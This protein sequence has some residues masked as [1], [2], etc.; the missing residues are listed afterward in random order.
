MK[1]VRLVAI[2]S[3]LSLHLSLLSLTTTSLHAGEIHDA[4]ATGDLNKVRSLIEADPTLLEA[5][6]DMGLTPLH[7]ACFTGQVAVANFLIA[8][9]ADVTA[10]DNF[11]MTPLHRTCFVPGQDLALIQRL[12]GQGADVNAEGY[13]GLTPLHWIAKSGDL[14]AARLLIDHGADINGYDTYSGK[15]GTASISGTV[16]QVAINF[17]PNETLA[18]FLVENGAKLNRKD[19]A[20]NTELHLAATKGY[21]DLAQVLVAHGVDVNAV[22]GDNRTAL[23]Y[24]AKHGYRRVADALLAAGAKESAIVETNF[25]KAPQLAAALKEGEAYLWYL[26]GGYAV[27]TRKDLLLFNPNGVDESL[28]AGLANGHLNPNELEGLKIIVLI[29]NPE[30]WPLR[31]EIFELAKRMRV[32][33]VISHGLSASDT[34]NPTIPAYR[35]AVPNESFSISGIQVHTIKAMG[36]GFGYLVEADGVRILFAGLHVS[37]NEDSL[38]A[39][40]RK[41]IDYLKPFGPVDFAIVSV[42]AHTNEIKNAYEPHLYLLDQLS[43]KAVYLLGANNPEQYPKCVEILRARNIPV[44]YPEGGLAM[45][46]RFHFVRDQALAASQSPESEVLS[47]EYLGQPPPGATPEVFARGIVSTDDL[48]HSAPSFSPDGN[49]VYWR[50]SRRTGPANKERLAFNITMRR[51]HGRWSHPRRGPFDSQL[52]FSV[53]GRRAYFSSPPHSETAPRQ[54]IVD[55]WCSEREGE[56]WSEPKCLDLLVRYPELRSVRLATVSRKGT[57]YLEAYA[58]GPLND[59]GIYRCELINGKYAKPEL[60]PRSINLPPFLNWT[61]FISPDESYLLFSSNR[62]DPDHD[63][64]DLYLSRHLADG[65]WTEPVSLGDPVNSNRQERF[66]LLSPDGKYLFF[67]RPTPGHDQ[68]VYWVDAA[69]IPA[70]QATTNLP[71]EIKK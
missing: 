54:P 1:F 24:A 20:G 45:G 2:T 69:T 67:T 15:I 52:V 27:K 62:R 48:E 3:V 26:G 35:L 57:L 39:K 49:E 38:L 36:G 47:G 4:A 18:K 37:S 58:P 65:S 7:K 33:F 40:Y 22:N 16:L 68:D 43:P 21:A 44:S 5:R 51:E 34:G 50:V 8:K 11:R 61:P 28:E 10:R 9:G 19:S 41:E 59:S 71:K 12:I 53:D 17:G 31:P 13:N 56:S 64:G 6:G 66:P 30:R 46:E 70:L 23:Y 55:V 60:L 63:A 42:S 29:S 32:D 25:G 14:K